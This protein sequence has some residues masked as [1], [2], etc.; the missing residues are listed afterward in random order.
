MC[1]SFFRTFPAPGKSFEIQA[2][3]VA[4]RVSCDAGDRGGPAARLARG[5]TTGL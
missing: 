1:I 2:E 3:S 5:V 4:P